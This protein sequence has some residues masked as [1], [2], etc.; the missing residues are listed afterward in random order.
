MRAKGAVPVN[1][2]VQAILA[3]I[4]TLAAIGLAN[5]AWSHWDGLT[6]PRPGTEKRE[7]RQA[8]GD[9]RSA[10]VQADEDR[11]RA[12]GSAEMAAI[13]DAGGQ[14]LATVAVVAADP[15]PD[16]APAVLLTLRAA[17]TGS[18]PFTFDP[19]LLALRDRWGFLHRGA[20]DPDGVDAAPAVANPS[21]PAA[22]RGAD[23]TDATPGPRRAR[24]R[25][26]RPD[27]RG[28]ASTPRSGEDNPALSSAAT[29]VATAG[30]TWTVDPGQTQER[31]VRIALPPG[32]RIA[33]ILYEPTPRQIVILADLAAERERA[34]AGR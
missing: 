1:R 34:D 29:P 17:N 30:G 7:G 3:V 12:D 24:D 4:L 25:A 32:A 23:R 31:T 26:D 9:R 16:G 13:V 18:A 27:R 11:G 22:R 20:A 33:Q 15:A 28:G 6:T 8:E 19:G 14:E 10:P 5:A 2:I 21:T